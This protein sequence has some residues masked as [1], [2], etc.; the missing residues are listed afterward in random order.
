MTEQQLQRAEP[1]AVATTN[2]P[3]QVMGLLQTAMSSGMAPEQVE[4]L[5]D[6]YERLQARQAEQQFA[7]AMAAFQA[8]VPPISKN[9]EVNTGRY[10]YDYAEL[11]HIAA[12]I[13]PI[14]EEHGLSYTWESEQHDGR[15]VV[16]CIL[17]HSG[18]HSTRTTFTVPVDTASRMNAQQATASALSYA[19]RYALILVLGLTTTGERDDDGVAAG[20]QTI[21]DT[22]AADLQAMASEVGAD[23]AKFLAYL[24]VG[25]F[26]SIA[27]KDYPRALKALEAKRRKEAQ[28]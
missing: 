13:R 2:G 20:S 10:S 11:D 25:S 17:R 21:T 12:V 22:Q 16:S 27:E 18:G 4:K 26:N 3:D 28:G 7:A 1:T 14:L 19:R 9:R 24:R 23:E 15:M 5:V 6:L 8:E